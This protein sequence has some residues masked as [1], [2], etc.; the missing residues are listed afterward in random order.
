M[1]A[2]C[3][4]SF[5]MDWRILVS[6]FIPRQKQGIKFINICQS[7]LK[8]ETHSKIVQQDIYV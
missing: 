1:E 7:M 3:V 6:Y 4:G 2:K 8:L 5:N